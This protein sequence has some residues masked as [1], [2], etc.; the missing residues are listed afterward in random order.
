MNPEAEDLGLKF[1]LTTMP[2]VDSSGMGT[3]KEEGGRQ[4]REGK[5]R[6]GGRRKEGA[7]EGKGRRREEG[8]GRRERESL[9]EERAR[10]LWKIM[11]PEAEDLGLK[12]ILTTMPRMDSSGMG[13]KKEEGG[14]QRREGKE[15]RK[16]G[17]G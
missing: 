14:R 17:E 2:Q 9:L 5:E 8:G 10:G 12:F 7:R 4:R 6:R 11:N 3:K 1:I 15:R 13:T 16:E